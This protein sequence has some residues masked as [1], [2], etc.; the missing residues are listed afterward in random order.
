MSILYF[1]FSTFSLTRNVISTSFVFFIKFHRFDITG[2]KLSFFAERQIFK[3][4]F[5]HRFF[6]KKFVLVEVFGQAEK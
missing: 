1:Y 6:L 5:K 3:I 2:Q 4:Y